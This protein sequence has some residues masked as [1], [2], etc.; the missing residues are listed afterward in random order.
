MELI[1][2]T[3]NKHKAEE[4][5]EI[6]GIDG[7]KITTLEDLGYTNDI[8]ETGFTLSEN[9]LIKSKTIYEEYGGHVFSEDTGLEVMALDMAPGV[10]TARYAGE[11]RDAGANMDKL[12]AALGNGM[13]RTARFRTVVSLIW[14]GKEYF[15]SGIVNGTIAYE[16]SGEAGFGY[17]PIFI[18]YGHMKTFA[19]LASDVKNGISHRYRAI[20]G[21]QRYLNQRMGL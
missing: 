20:S 17:D 4:V 12:L 14:E 21:M 2:A 19:E 9:A 1:F 16:K 13:D 5:H 6:L 11:G 15:F 3:H 10:H 7:L 8:E 18:P